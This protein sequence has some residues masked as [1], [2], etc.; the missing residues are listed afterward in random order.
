[1]SAVL[2]RDLERE[3]RE[4]VERAHLKM[5]AD[6]RAVGDA[7]HRVRVILDGRTS[8]A[9]N[10]TADELSRRLE[11]AAI[12]LGGVPADLQADVRR[13]VHGDV[14][15]LRNRVEELAE[16]EARQREWRPWED[17]PA[18]KIAAVLKTAVKTADAELAAARRRIGECTTSDEMRAALRDVE[19]VR[20]RVDADR[21]AALCQAEDMFARVAIEHRRAVAA[22]L[23]EWIRRVD[24]DFD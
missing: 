6:A 19:A 7:A 22:G 21:R 12:E 3:R 5:L 14:L 13:M 15:A 10:P 1:M 24:P 17:S 20:V 8:A 16:L 11:N 18:E 23:A 4:D 2:I 9:K